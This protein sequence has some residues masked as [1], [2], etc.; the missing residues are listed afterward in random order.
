V[1]ATIHQLLKKISH[2]LLH[3]VC[4]GCEKE[5][6]HN[7]GSPVCFSTSINYGHGKRRSISLVMMYDVQQAPWLRLMSSPAAFDQRVAGTG[8][9]RR[10][11]IHLGTAYGVRELAESRT[12]RIWHRTPWSLARPEC[13]P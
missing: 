3:F 11:N 2:F 10:S 12:D 13:C 8:V 5:N 4:E 9:N 6:C 7:I 1:T